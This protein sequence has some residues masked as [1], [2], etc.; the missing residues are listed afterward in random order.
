MARSNVFKKRSNE[1]LP[2]SLI[3]KFSHRDSTHYGIV[4]NISEK[5]MFINSGVILPLDTR[6]KLSF[7][8]KKGELDVPV[9][10]RWSQNLDGFYDSMGVELVKPSKRYLQL[11]DKV[12]EARLTA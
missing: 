12:K 1:R 11:V 8:L 10:V 9:I 2:S 7:L 3:V 4:S 5:G 6:L